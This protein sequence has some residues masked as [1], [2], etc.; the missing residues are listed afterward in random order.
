MQTPCGAPVSRRDLLGRSAILVL[1]TVGAT[2]AK[3]AGIAIA[4][5]AGHA[6]RLLRGMPPEVTPNDQFYIISKNF[7]DPTVDVSRWSL[8]VT[9]L[10]NKPLRLSLEEL[11]KTAP[12]V[13]R[14]QTL[15]CIS[16]EVGGDLISNA[17]WKGIRMKDLLD[18]AGV[19]EGATTVIMRSVDNYSESL[20]L[21]VAVDPA[22]LLA[23]Q[24]NGMPVPQKHG[25][26]VRVL[27]FNRYGMKMPKWLTN[28]EVAN[29]DY[30]G[31]WERQGW[32]KQAI[33]KISSTF[34]V[35]TKNGVVFALGGW[36]FAGD[37]GISKVE[38]SPD[39]GKT[40]IPAA[41][42][43][44]MGKNCWQFWS[45]EWKPPAKGDYALKVRATDGTGQP[46][47][48]QPKP[49]LPDGGQGYHTVR[50]RFD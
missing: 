7:L 33:V 14:Y 18:L 4:R 19:K 15:E 2:L 45:L 6:F 41:V 49:T 8:E 26:P 30:T 42:K 10:V 31:Y 5:A 50:V 46:Q 43:D 28:I 40:W 36:A 3:S 11:T 9:G 32:S 12:S 16:N 34:R 29:H 22:T 35:E 23:Y 27:L 13:E 38:V 37:R 21:E 48:G 17:K 47:P 25:A 39:N 20:P 1:V 24:M 44:P